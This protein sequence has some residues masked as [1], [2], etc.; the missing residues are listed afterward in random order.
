MIRQRLKTLKEFVRGIRNNI[1]KTNIEKSER[2]EYNPANNRDSEEDSIYFIKFDFSFFSDNSDYTDSD[3]SKN[4]LFLDE[5]K[6]FY[7]RN[8]YRSVPYIKDLDFAGLLPL[9]SEPRNI[10]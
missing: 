1:E 10:K 3:I 9:I 5:P 2:S 6:T 8:A 7:R 4:D